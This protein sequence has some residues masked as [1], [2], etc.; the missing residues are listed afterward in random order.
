MK[1]FR[2][3]IKLLEAN[4]EAIQVELPIPLDGAEP[5]LSKE[6]INFHYNVLHKGYI[7]KVKKGIDVDF[8]LA[9]VKLHNIWFSQFRSPGNQ[10]PHGNIKTLIDDKFGN[11]EN[12]KN[13]FSDIA[14]SIHG[15]GWCYLSY[16]GHIK[17]IHNH[18]FFNDILLLIDIWEHSWLDFSQ[19]E[20]PNK[21]LYLQNIWEIINWDVINFRVIK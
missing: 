16:D 5:V 3:Y 2:Y 19:N 6:N 12:F 1:D 8:N 4:E 18:E 9:G 7:D 15:S 20:T 14:K 21:D 11:F 13:N 10:I 17:V